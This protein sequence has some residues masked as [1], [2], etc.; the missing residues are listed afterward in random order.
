MADTATF[1]S[2]GGV[3]TGTGTAASLS[4][5]GDGAWH[6][7]SGA[8]LT[9]PGGV[10]VGTTEAAQLLI[11]GAASLVG[12]GSAGASIAAQ[13]GASGSSVN[14]SGI[15]SE[16]Q[17][18]GALIIG[19]A[20][21]GALNIT[22]G[23]TVTAS[24]IDLA[25][26]ANSAG[27][28]S[29]SG[30]NSTLMTTGSLAVGDLGSGD[31]SV[32]GSANATIGGDLDFGQGA[33]SSG[34]IDLETTGTVTV[35]GGLNFGAGGPGVLTLGPNTDLVLSGGING[36]PGAQLNLFNT[37]DPA[38]YSINSTDNIS[39]A[40]HPLQ[41]Q[42]YPAYVAAT[43]FNLSHGVTY[44]LDTPVI[45]AAS[46][47]MIGGSGDTTANTLILN[48]D[49]LSSDTSIA[50]GNAHGTLAIGSDQLATSD[51]P[52]SGTGPFTTEPNPNLGQLL[53]GDFEATI[54][55]FQAGDQIRVD[56]GLASAADGTLSQN[57]ALVSVVDIANGDTLGVL[58][59]VSSAQATA[60]IGDGAITLVPCFAAGTRICTAR[61]EV[62]VEAIGVG[63]RVRVLLGGGAG[64]GFA[65]VIWVGRREVDCASHATPR[66]VWPVRVAAGAFG[67]GRPHS[68]LW[69]SPDHAVFVEDVLIPVR[70]L[71][72]GSTIVQ[73]PVDRVVYHH[74]ELEQHDVLLAQGLPAES[75]L[76]MR[77]GSNYANRPGPV[78]LYPDYSARMWEAFGC[79]R[80]VVTGPELD[81]ARALVAGF[82][83]EREAA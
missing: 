39:G 21:D 23:A 15:G 58:T 57:G 55:G 18:N 25:T 12:T 52:A 67:P 82:A 44:T 59:F 68:E 29:I 70:C 54:G 14:V 49:S 64:D 34:V 36:G 33:G 41:T 81:A 9:T 10:T 80:L 50:F 17:M 78:R 11:N 26:Q 76:D 5:G 28:L 45:Y 66:K 61:G 2:G 30:N 53:I 20:G 56:T 16:W 38:P 35:D 62:A 22:A 24:T 83:A 48:A 73:V 37:I 69:L 19:D 6:L 32:L 40:F 3:I 60:A 75:F 43:A 74:V 65:E 13:S 7:G 4:F 46:S 71:V 72:N 77:D 63:E 47:F 42:A 31:L 8:A 51:V 27:D 1:S 79:A